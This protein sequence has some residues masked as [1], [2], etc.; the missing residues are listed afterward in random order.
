MRSY[1]WHRNLQP[2]SQT[3]KSWDT[4]AYLRRFPVHPGPTRPFTPQTKID[5]CIQNLF[6]VSILF[7]GGGGGGGGGENVQ[8]SFEKDALFCEGTQK[9]QKNM[10]TAL[11]SQELLSTIVVKTLINDNNTEF[12]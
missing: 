3:Q 9:W 8:E 5:A 1:N 6:R 7:W 11:L 10:N 4:F 12:T 2:K